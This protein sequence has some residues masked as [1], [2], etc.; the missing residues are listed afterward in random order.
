MTCGQD[1]T[2]EMSYTGHYN[3]LKEAFRTLGI[4]SNAV[5]HTG[6]GAGARMADL[7]GASEESVRRLGRWTSGAMHGCYMTNL[8]LPAMRALAGFPADQQVFFLARAAID[9]PLQLQC[10]IFPKIEECLEGNNPDE[11]SETDEDRSK[12]GFLKALMYMR[13]VIY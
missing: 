9:P 1:K 13:K 10:Q 4:H 3:P 12:T 2:H 6:R 11:S 5:T 7:S 8:P